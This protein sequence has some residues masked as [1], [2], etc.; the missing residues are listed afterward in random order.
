MPRNPEAFSSKLKAV[1]KAGVS[2]ILGEDPALEINRIFFE[3]YQGAETPYISPRA[4]TNPPIEL[5]EAALI[6][7]ALKTT[8]PDIRYLPWST[9]RFS[10]GY[11]LALMSAFTDM[12]S[13]F[14][15]YDNFPPSA[16]RIFVDRIIDLSRSRNRQI[17]IPEQFEVGLDLSDGHVLGAAVI[18]HGGARS[19]ARASDTSVD[20][21]LRYTTDEIKTW[22]DCVSTFESISGRYPDPAADTYHFWGTFIPGLLS[23]EKDRLKDVVLNP[24]YKLL[25][26]NMASI[27]DVLRYRLMKKSGEPHQVADITGYHIGSMVGAA[28]REKAA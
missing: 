4:H 16:S 7:K 25:Y 28:L 24:T 9:S 12:H 18:A 8:C 5:I 15:P 14:I 20:D 23:E 19:I 2:G 27:T 11:H 1:L 6:D 26:T 10:Q 21:K 17:T 13:G 22:R 3:S